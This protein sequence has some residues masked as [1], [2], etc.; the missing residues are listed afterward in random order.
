[1]IWTI[2]A[3]VGAFFIFKD[4]LFGRHP[5]NEA[6]EWIMFT[7]LACLFSLIQALACVGAAWLLGWLFKTVPVEVSRKKLVAIRDKDGITGQ[8]FLGTGFVRGDQYYF[9]YRTNS[10][11]SVTPGKVYAGSGVRV[12]EEDRTDAE[13]VSYEWQLASKWAWLVAM[14]IIIDAD[15]SYDFHVPKG[16]VRTGYTM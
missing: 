7:F 10:D 8:F 6:F 12:Y 11:G 9:Y 5:P 13:L 14:P 2:P 4:M 16:T 3:L 1:M 15:W